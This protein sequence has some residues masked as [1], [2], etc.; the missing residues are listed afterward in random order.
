MTFLFTKEAFED[1]RFLT[2]AIHRFLG[3]KFV[4]LGPTGTFSRINCTRGNNFAFSLPFR[5]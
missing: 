2:L 3:A 4:R 1:S 5:L